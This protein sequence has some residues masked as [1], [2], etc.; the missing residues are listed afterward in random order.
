MRS[1]LITLALAAGFCL[2]GFS[3]TAVAQSDAEIA[4][5]KARTAFQGEQ[6]TTARD[7]LIT[8]SQTDRENPD[9]FLLLG[10][11]HY[12]LGD[13]DKAIVAWKR[14]LDLAPAQA[15]AR[16]MVDALQGKLVDVDVRLNVVRALLSDGLG[17]AALSDIGSLKRASL[18]DDQKTKLLLLEAESFIAIGQGSMAMKSLRELTIRY[19]Q[20]SE[21]AAV[22]LLTGKAKLAADSGDSAVSIQQGLA[23]LTAVKK[24]LPDSAEAAAADLALISFRLLQAQDAVDELAAWIAAHAEHRDIRAAHRM[25]VEAVSIFLHEATRLG[26][27]ETDADLSGPEKTA[28][29][30]ASHAL[31]SLKR[32]DESLE[33]TQQIVNHIRTRFIH[34]GAFAAADQA[35]QPLLALQL[36]QASRLTLQTALTEARDAAAA[37]ELSFILTVVHEGDQQPNVLEN[38]IRKHDQHP[39]VGEA[40]RKLITAYLEQTKR[41]GTATAKTVLSNFDKSALTATQELLAEPKTSAEKAKLIADWLRYLQDHYSARGAHAASIEAQQG[42]LT[43]QLPRSLRLMVLG[44]LAN[45][46]RALAISRLDSAVARGESL[47]AGPLPADLAALLTTLQTINQ[48]YPAQPSWTIQAGVASQLSVL[49]Q[50]IPWPAK[51]V[52]VKATDNWAMLFAVPVVAADQEAK[53]S[54]TALD[55][56]ESIVSAAASVTQTSARGLAAKTHQQMLDA[57]DEDHRLWPHVAIRQ[58]ALRLADDGADF[59]ERASEGRGQ[60]NADF[61]DDQ[62]AIVQLASKVISLHPGKAAEVL[63]LLEPFLTLR[64][65]AGHEA[66]VEEAYAL[67]E[68]NLPPPQLRA[69]RL[70][71]AQETIGRVIAD[72]ERL[73]GN[74]FQPSDQLDAALEDALVACYQLQSNVEPESDFAKSV[75]VVRSAVV[76]HYR[77]LRYYDAAVAAISAAAENRV[78]WLDAMAEYELASLNLSKALDGLAEQ[79]KKFGGRENVTLTPAVNEAIAGLEKFITDRSDSRFVTDAVNSMLSVGQRFQGY[80]KYEIAAQIYARLE[81]FAAATESLQHAPP[82]TATVGQR[83]ALAVATALHTKASKELEKAATT[84]SDPPDQ[85]S[86]SFKAAVAAYQSVITNDADSPHVSTAIGKIMEIALEHATA[87]SW[88]VADGVYASLQSQQLPLRQP[89]QLDLARALCEMGKVMPEHAHAVLAAITLWPRAVKVDVFMDSAIAMST[90]GPGS[91]SAGGMLGGGLGGFGG[92]ASDEMG[93]AAPEAPAPPAGRVADLAPT[94][95][96]FGDDAGQMPAAA[97]ESFRAR[98][99]RQSE[100]LAAVRRQ[101]AVMASQVALMRDKEIRQIVRTPEQA[102]TAQQTEGQQ[103]ATTTAPVLS[104]AEIARRQNV[105]DAAY[106]KLQ[107]IRKTYADTLT[108]GQARDEIMVIINHWRSILQWERSAKLA[109]RFLDDNPDDLQLPELRHGIARDYLAWAAGAVKPGMSKQELLDKVNERFQLAR[110]E[111]AGIIAA[112]PDRQSL[113]H[114]A[115]WDIAGSHLSQARVVAGVSS[116]LARGQ[117][118]RAANELLQTADLYHDHPKINELPQMLWNIGEELTRRRFFDEA[119]TV[120]NEMTLHYPGNALAEQAALKIAQTYQHQLRLPL[121]AVE[122]YLELNFARGGSDAS[123][124]DAIFQ[125]ASQLMNEHR[126]VESLHVLE[127]FVDSFPKHASAGQALTMIGQVHQTNEVWEDAIAAYRRVILEYDQGNWAQQSKWSIAE[128]TI[129]LSRWEEAQGAYREYQKAYPEDPKVAEATKRLEILKDLARYQKVVDEQGQRKAFDAQYQIAA[130][131]RNKLSNPVKAIIEYKK[132]AD[133]W[134]ESHLADD[135]L[136]QVGMIYMQLGQTEDARDAFFA[137]ADRYPTSPLADDALFQVGASFESEAETLAGVTRGKASQ[138]AAEAAQKRA[139]ALSQDNRRVRREQNVQQI[140]KLKK[141]G[142]KAEVERQTALQAALN[143]QFDQANASV[144]ANWAAQQEEAL[145]TA[146][147]ADR[148]DKINAALRKAVSNFRRAASVASADKA[149]DA[150]L[151]MAQIY[152]QRL[153]D[154]DSAMSTWLEIVKQ[155]SGTT[156]AEDAS[157]KIAKYYESHEKYADAIQAYNSFLR[158]YRRSPKA[159]DAQAAIAE[160]HEQLGNWVE[161]MDA[162]TNYIN[163]YPQGTMAGKAKEQIAWIKTYRL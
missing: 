132:V 112:F 134:P 4:M 45:S 149:D 147:L 87:G 162:Y 123:L 13:V 103:Q 55:V 1:F 24:D 18:S 156:V 21:S 35:I 126:W 111:L 160:N 14:T 104:E 12:Q 79:T 3:P 80:E 144:V 85:L 58:L 25:M 155:Y 20:Q 137:T 15:Y 47:P 143:V 135:A 65:D 84:K 152:D 140:A 92:G 44:G 7:L 153:K 30:A 145:T 90:N 142:K 81:K 64:R 96:P 39:K 72:H 22:R 130:I 127:T 88:E 125:I 98:A 117:F 141:A 42:L 95:D 37:V 139:Y 41:S 138:I 102:K 106:A 11:A 77:N 66:V 70:A 146:Q 48:E 10:K 9:I 148:Q 115:Q 71:V 52:Q 99:A 121:K 105:L 114:Q 68:N 19:P 161:A 40:R 26:K 110:T 16:R 63:G 5:Q 78:D 50:R 46:Q 62:K 108:A 28:L 86:D 101:Q 38:W 89:E 131:V 49:G 82:G 56:I 31:K 150:L 128:C 8:A 57:L 94:D 151:R 120:W 158:N 75:R 34:E 32:T 54:K 109:K 61:S 6:Y 157:W 33:L 159:S 36:P 83:A 107:A 154:S 122:S 91:G 119:I 100:L 118:V 76:A 17:K 69:V 74:G 29:K 93:L 27:P 133:R 124:Q 97:N 67:L 53:V 59:R 116:T 136:F 163:N 129:N 73:L 2:A 113:K 23:L 51:V 60:V 43:I